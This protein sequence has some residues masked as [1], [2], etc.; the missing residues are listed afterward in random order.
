MERVKHA[1]TNT[2]NMLGEKELD[3]SPLWEEGVL[4]PSD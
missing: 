3:D 4:N 1:Q 2:S